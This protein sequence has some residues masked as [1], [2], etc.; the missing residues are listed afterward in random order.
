MQANV[1]SIDRVVRIVVGLGLIGATL[2]GAIGGWGWIGIVPILTGIFARCPAYV[3]FGM[4][5]C[6]KPNVRGE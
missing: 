1:G 2:A 5:T 4:S 3:P 6:K